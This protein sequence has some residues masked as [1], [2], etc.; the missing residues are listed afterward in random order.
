MLPP[1]IQTV[2]DLYSLPHAKTNKI[3]VAGNNFTRASVVTV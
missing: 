3:K 2:S 1:S